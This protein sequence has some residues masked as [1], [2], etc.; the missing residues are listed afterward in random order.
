MI[1]KYDKLH[2]KIS[3]KTG[4]S[5]RVIEAI[6]TQVL[7]GGI[8]PE[9]LKEFWTEIM[10]RSC[11]HRKQSRESYGNLLIELQNFKFKDL[12]VILQPL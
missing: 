5:V 10:N 6:R 1:D 11:S 4:Y 12:P 8:N 9:D 3:K 2:K 7:G